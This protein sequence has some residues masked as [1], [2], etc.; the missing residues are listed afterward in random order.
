MEMVKNK[1]EKEKKVNKSPSKNQ[2]RGRR[3]SKGS[4]TKVNTKRKAPSRTQEKR[5]VYSDDS[6][7][8]E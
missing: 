6:S 3:G 5:D 8:S 1:K 4:M 7:D 2:K